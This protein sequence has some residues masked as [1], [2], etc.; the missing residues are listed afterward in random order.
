MVPAGTSP[1]LHTHSQGDSYIISTLGPWALLV[2]NPPN[3]TVR[4]PQFCMLAHCLCSLTLAQQ[5]SQTPP[6]KT[7]LPSLPS[8]ARWS[9]LTLLSNARSST[10]P[11]NALTPPSNA[12]TP[13]SNAPTPPFDAR[14]PPSNARS[15]ILL[16][17]ARSPNLLSNARLATLLTNTHSPTVL[18]NTC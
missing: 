2:A 12:P 15:P 1:C 13:P 11:S 6:T 16:P 4:T 7:R 10:P 9:I 18:S 5:L 14:T 17:N 3:P 8:S